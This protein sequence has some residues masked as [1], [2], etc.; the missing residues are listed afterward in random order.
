MKKFSMLLLSMV[1]TAAM[2]MP[3]LADELRGH[4][5]AVDADKGTITLVEGQKDYNFSTTTDTQFLNLKGGA[6]ANG[7]KSGDLREGRR[8]VVHYDTKDGQM[9]LTSLKIRP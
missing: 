6:L 5:K 2:L 3:G 8:V 1:L 4:I 7:I 9:V